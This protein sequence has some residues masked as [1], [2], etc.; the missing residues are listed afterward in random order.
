METEQI[1]Y[2]VI[3]TANPVMMPPIRQIPNRRHFSMGRLIGD[4]Q[5]H[6]EFYP[7]FNLI[8]NTNEPSIYLVGIFDNRD[9]AERVASLNSSRKILGPTKLSP[10][11]PSI[12]F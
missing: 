2:V 8:R 1:L 6:P 11:I 7:E 9:A 4:Q 12:I 5:I 3:E 10:N